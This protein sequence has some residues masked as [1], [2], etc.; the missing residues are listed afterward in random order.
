MSSWDQLR[1]EL[2]L[3]QSEDR[4]ANAWWRDDDAVSV[5]PA[6]ETL[7]RF[8]QDYKV[9]LALAVIPAALQD[10]LVERLVET[11]DTRV[12]QHGWSHQNHMPEGR[13]KQELDDVRDIG[14]VVADLRH[15]FSVLQSRF[16]NR[17]LPV[18]V[19]PWNRVA[20]DVVA[21][22]HSLGFCGISTFN[23]RKAA[24]PYKGIMQ[25]N[26]HVDVIDWRGIRGFV[27]EDAALGAMIEHLAA[28]R[29]GQ[30]DADE[31]TGILTH[32]LVHDE[33][34]TKFLDNLFSMDHSALRWLRIPGVFP[35]Q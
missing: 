7:L 33:A 11:L 27:G 10:D 13:K 24:E 25:V 21:A 26:T 16:G 8:E 9:P 31:P 4:I 19:P 35:W 30:V 23:A 20:E 32:H 17:F 34:T 15:G 3:W 29:T 2:D 28:R 12:L 1:A 22:L 5:T 6:L 14:D 18:L